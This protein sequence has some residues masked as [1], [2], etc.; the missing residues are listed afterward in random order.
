[1]SESRITSSSKDTSKK[2]RR[3]LNEKELGTL[4]AYCK[5]PLRLHHMLEKDL[6]KPNGQSGEYTVD[7]TSM[8]AELHDSL[9]EQGPDDALL[10]LA[11][12][13]WIMEDYC[14]DHYADQDALRVLCTEL[15]CESENVIHDLGRL[16]IDLD[17]YKSEISEKE[18]Y[19]HLANV[20]D[21]LCVLA[22][23]YQELINA[24]Q[25]IHRKDLSQIARLLCYQAEAQA[26]HAWSYV[27]VMMKPGEREEKE[28][29]LSDIPL[30]Y[31]MQPDQDPNKVID[32][33]LFRRK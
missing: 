11:L 21:S 4:Y 7:I 13:G 10:S 8:L 19:E 24:F 12:M 15:K 23:I 16:R 33:S 22:S 14:S 9:S 2:M 26:D 28:P 3:R 25:E 1:M 27:E 32:L 18:I 17:S 5:S 29:Y 6:P 30:P 20:P 31:D